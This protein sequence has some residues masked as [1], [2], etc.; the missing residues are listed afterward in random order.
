[1]CDIYN[2]MVIYILLSAILR[3]LSADNDN[4]Y[5]Q[6]YLSPFR[7]VQHLNKLLKDGPWKCSLSLA[8]KLR[9]TMK[10]IKSLI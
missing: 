10:Q 8:L 3:G 1:M 2:S 4:T 5:I 6:V 7:F 9:D